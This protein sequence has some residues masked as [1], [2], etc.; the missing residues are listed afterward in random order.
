MNTRLFEIFA[1]TLDNLPPE[2]IRRIAEMEQQ[3]LEDDLSE[4]RILEDLETES[5]L[6]FCRFINS[7]NHEDQE[8][9]LKLPLWHARYYRSIIKRLIQ[10]RE[11]PN[12]ALQKFEAAISTDHWKSL[13]G[14]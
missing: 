2:G 13:K 7:Y 3:M 6:A 1:E 11:L 9:F 10:A 4:K 5:I 8:F 12:D 14:D